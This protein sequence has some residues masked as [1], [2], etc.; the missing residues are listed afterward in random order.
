M[1]LFDGVRLTIKQKAQLNQP[2]PDVLS[3]YDIAELWSDDPDLQKLYLNRLEIGFMVDWNDWEYKE[4]ASPSREGMLLYENQ[5]YLDI[6]ISY[7]QFRDWLISYDEELPKDCLLANWWKNKSFDQANDPT[8]SSQSESS[9]NKK[10]K[11]KHEQRDEDFKE[12]LKEK[13]TDFDI[14]KLKKSEIQEDLKSRN[15]NLWTFDFD[16][17]CKYTK[18]YS[19]KRGRKRKPV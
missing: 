16:G 18:L 19:G 11:L 13:G 10:R 5:K 15:K 3:I 6:F 4:M 2:L 1:A 8:E 9:V 12:Y 17:W 7:V 14:N